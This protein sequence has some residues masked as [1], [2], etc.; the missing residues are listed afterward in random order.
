[1]NNKKAVIKENI[2]NTIG[3][4][5]MLDE[6]I[7]LLDYKCDYDLEG[8]LAQGC[9][10]IL[11]TAVF[12]QKTI[13][14]PKIA[15]NPFAGHGG[16][17]TF[18]VRTP[19]G[20][21][22]MGR[23]FDYK[24]SRVMVVWTHPKKGYRSMSVCNQNH[25]LYVDLRKSRRPLR[26]LAAPYIS[27]DGI[28]EKGLACAILELL[29]KPTRQQRGKTPITTNVALRGVLDT[30]A[31]VEEA[32]AF[33]KKYDMRDVLGACYHYFFTDADNNSA[34][35]EYVDGDMYVYRQKKP[36]ES[37]KLTNFFITPHGVCREKGR[38]RYEKM[39]CALNDT[40]VMDENR[41]MELLKSVMV[42]FRSKYKVFRITTSWSAVF[43]CTDRSMLL[44]AGMDYSRRYKLSLDAPCQA[45]L[46][47]GE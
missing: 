7:C 5:K 39:E 33:L 37:M 41:A 34:I 9:P 13:H 21:V 46:V 20:K 30:C 28:N 19:D 43:N 38:D 31:T 40:P 44:C 12:F 6:H 4:L 15:P 26:V 42:C 35:V 18:N 47:E 8:M 25:A 14:S 27:M 22:L 3:T 23:N 1:M 24:E 2:N 36:D 32:I 45:A 29:G 11:K 17:S 10:S 16:C